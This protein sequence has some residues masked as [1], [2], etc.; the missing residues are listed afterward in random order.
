M[1]NEKSSQE[2]SRLLFQL[3]TGVQ[4]YRVTT[5]DSNL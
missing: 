5:K 1:S 4:N 2:G 3:R